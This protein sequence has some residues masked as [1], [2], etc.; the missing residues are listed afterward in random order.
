M[1]SKFFLGF[2]L[3]T[4]IFSV[5][6][7]LSHMHLPA[8]KK[9]AEA[10]EEAFLAAEAQVKEA[11]EMAQAEQAEAKAARAAAD[12]SKVV[13]LETREAAAKI[14]K[15]FAT[16]S[17]VAK[18]AFV[19]SALAYAGYKHS[20]NKAEA[21][22]QAEEAKE[23]ELANKAWYTKVYASA[24]DGI[25]SGY[26]TVQTACVNGYDVAKKYA[27]EK[28]YHVATGAAAAAV[29]AYGAYSLC[30]GDVATN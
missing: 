2:S 15:N 10:A 17:K 6:A 7:D 4:V 11:L 9:A 19:G 14:L 28:P 20:A 18:A 24:K 16:A 26:N 8:Y 25:V 30:Y 5:N 23:A 21:A 13:A 1:T 27:I 12:T 3:L 29:L 22:K